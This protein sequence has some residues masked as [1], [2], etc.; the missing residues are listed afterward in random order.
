[1]LDFT[2]TDEQRMMVDTARA[3]MREE[4]IE[5][6]LDMALDKSGEFPHSIFK[7]LWEAGLI[8]LEVPEAYGGAGLSCV[9][10]VLIQ[11]E[12]HYGCLGISTSVIAN[13]M[14]AMP[15]ILSQASHEALAKKYLGMLTEAPTY[16]AYGCSE[17]DAGS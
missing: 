8:N 9:E 14:G 11:E 4:V 1:M 6:K 2:L 12:I 13:N 17:P 10:H 16:C 3:L 15:V 7:T 5:P